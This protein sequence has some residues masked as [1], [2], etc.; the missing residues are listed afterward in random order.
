[1]SWARYAT[2][3]IWRVRAF[4]LTKGSFDGSGL[5]IQCAEYKMPDGSW[6]TLFW[7]MQIPVT[8]TLYQVKEGSNLPIYNFVEGIQP[9]FD[10]VPFRPMLWTGPNVGYA[11]LAKSSAKA[12]D[13]IHV[14]SESKTP[15]KP[16][17]LEIA[18]KFE[19][20]N[21][22]H[23]QRYE[24]AAD[25]S[26]HVSVEMGGRLLSQKQWAHVHNF[27][28]RIQPN[29]TLFPET[30]RLSTPS[31][32]T[33][34]PPWKYI[35][36]RTVKKLGYNISD[37]HDNSENRSW[38]IGQLKIDI[39]PDSTKDEPKN[40]GKEYVSGYS[41]D[42]SRGAPA[43]G[44]ISAAD[45]Y[46]L[47][48]PTGPKPIDTFG[49][50]VLQTSLE[51]NSDNP[52]WEDFLPV[53]NVNIANLSDAQK[54]KLVPVVW[55][56]LREFHDPRQ[57]Y[58][59]KFNGEPVATGEDVVTTPYHQHGMSVRLAPLMFFKSTPAHLYSTVPPSPKKQD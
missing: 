8:L 18:A 57:R 2:N 25:G 31:P 48:M 42:I 9:A 33:V 53:Y 55:C 21:Y 6:K 27:Y 17:V 10:G 11:P 59:S 29:R 38:A 36:N 22:Q 45:I 5:D 52:P 28:V 40:V 41:I 34:Q 12:E 37:L 54:K 39:P 47:V 44:L 35:Q 13:V 19:M 23:I 58:T 14:K 20:E 4:V 46:F 56:V 30:F 3:G 7:R 24:F 1:M 26:I 16:A 32:S 51:G 43:D 50:G 49:T 15:A